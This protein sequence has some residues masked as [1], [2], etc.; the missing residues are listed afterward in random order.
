MSFSLHRW[1][2]VED[3]YLRALE[4][5][6]ACLMRHPASPQCNYHIGDLAKQQIGWL[7][8]AEEPFFRFGWKIKN[9]LPFSWISE[10][11]G[12][13]AVNLYALKSLKTSL[14]WI[15]IQSNLCLSATLVF[16][17]FAKSVNPRCC[18]YATGFLFA[19]P[20]RRWLQGS[21]LRGTPKSRCAWVFGSQAW[22]QNLQLGGDGLNPVQFY[23]AG[24]QWRRTC[25]CC[26]CWWW[27]W[28]CSDSVLISIVSSLCQPSLHWVPEH[29][30]VSC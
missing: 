6:E 30:K 24:W 12:P 13:F 5:S 1:R 15:L 19:R 7:K 18:M 10:R 17:A 25:C 27:G 23:M 28:Y 14:L 4:I 22:C 16:A 3:L 26:W 8:W 11:L 9:P 21:S 29:K 20:W 2:Y